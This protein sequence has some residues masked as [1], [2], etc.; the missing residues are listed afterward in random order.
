[1]LGRELLDGL[2]RNTRRVAIILHFHHIASGKEI[3][4]KLHQ[5]PKSYRLF[6]TISSPIPQDVFNDLVRLGVPLTI[7][8]VPNVGRDVRPFLIALAHPEV[9]SCDYVCKLHTKRNLNIHHENWIKAM[10]EGTIG[11]A[12][13]FN[14]IIRAFDADPELL[15]VGPEPVYKSGRKLMRANGLL[16]EKI[17]KKIFG[18]SPPEDWGFFA[19]TMFWARTS[20]LAAFADR[21]KMSKDLAFE[22]EPI[23]E[24]G[25]L[26][27]AFERMF[28]AIPVV[29]GGKIGLVNVETQAV[30]THKAP[31]PIN[32]ESMDAQFGLPPS[33][34]GA[35]AKSAGGTP[36]NTGS[37][38]EGA[39][40]FDATWYSTYYQDVAKLGM[41]P[42]K[43]Y[44]WLGKRLGR[45]PN[46][47]VLM[48][49]RPIQ[50]A[51]ANSASAI[52]AQ[53]VKK[54]TA[55]FVS[56]EPTT[57]PGYF[58]R[59]ERY[60]HAATRLGLRAEILT[61][62]R[63]RGASGL[64]DSARFVF[65]WRAVWGREL[66]SFVQEAGRL[67]VPVI[68]DV[69][70]LMICPEMATQQFIDAIRFNRIDAGK[71]KHHFEK[72][73][74]TMVSADVCTASTAS[75]AWYMRKDPSRKPAFVLPNGFSEEVYTL[76]R[77]AARARSRSCHDVIRIGY[78][79]GTTTHQA[80]F[81]VCAPAVAAILRE[82]E[83]SRLVLF[84]KGER[85]TLDLTEYPEFAGLEHR[86]E[87]R[88]FVDHR[89]LPTEIARFD[90]NLAP[91]EV[92]NPFCE[93]KS[94]LKFF[95]AAICDVPTI[96]S[97]TGPFAGVI[98]HGET[99]FLADTTEDWHAALRALIHD[100][101]LRR[102]IGREAHRRAL[103]TFGP[104]RRV[105][106]M[107]FLLDQ[108]EGG[109]RS[110]LSFSRHVAL[111][112]QPPPSVPM[113]DREIVM[114][115]E[116][117]KS[118]KVSVIVPLF[119]YEDYIEE[120]LNS[121]A[122]QT[123]PDIELIVVDDCSTDRSCIR[124]KN[125]MEAHRDRFRRVVLARHVQNQGLGASR[126]TAFDLADSL[127]VMTL[128]ADN[129]LLPSC[130]E[131]L[132]AIADREG[133]AFV[134]PTIRKF[135]DATG[136]MGDRP[137]RPAALIPGNY[138]DAMALISKE[139]WA[140]VGGYVPSRL[141]WQ[142][143]DL[144]CRFAERG[145]HGVHVDEEL[146]EYRVHQ[147]SM[148]RTRTDKVN[149]KV[150]LVKLMHHAHPWLDLIEEHRYARKV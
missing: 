119:N 5:L 19:G 96:A 8:D 40:P 122:A 118:A 102:R 106:L 13:T 22:P 111:S 117:G 126:N 28:G 51:A 135:G 31:G 37:A 34:R 39:Q 97:P 56:G 95:E 110:A 11:N 144:W 128:D 71:V 136:R 10:L 46:G 121:V 52:T 1:M 85:P 86:I 142:D 108:I 120:A 38:A 130:C 140:A 112:N 49:H 89:L 77:I 99:G 90:I 30:S 47:K 134:Y 2:R 114:E 149:N 132:L 60:A 103:W 9:R 66:A 14:D 131:K 33:K 27:H 42:L 18:I 26:P 101:S 148:L 72:I 150:E 48:D 23:G 133:A 45:M 57:K 124:A 137:Y 93:A 88:S 94:E 21:W 61:L 41:D 73:R 113:A 116:D 107:Q 75:L 138:I 24:D 98:S 74:Q 123:L 6:I 62:D 17:S 7:L 91:L 54:S 59:V 109:R 78:A 63:L 82:C 25:A 79:S 4:R 20:V 68:F 36:Q 125:W 12:N 53:S 16:C 146:A 69:D 65:I 87:W 76:S 83:H 58:Y 92:G 29:M 115:H 67:G 143:Y 141:G 139:A 84:Q 44:L 50:H 129:R 43:H 70:D 80:D 3:V 64:I 105:E 127:H 15:M 35:T 55:I 81:R 100:A 104:L 145:F 147:S 32:M